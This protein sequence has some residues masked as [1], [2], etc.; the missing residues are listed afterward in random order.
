MKAYDCYCSQSL[1]NRDSGYKAVVG[2]SATHL[3]GSA[4]CLVMWKPLDFA[5][6]AH[7]K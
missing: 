2:K 7:S 1:V 3:Q 6:W 5:F 4:H